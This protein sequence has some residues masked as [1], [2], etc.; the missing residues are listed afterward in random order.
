M[1][2]CSSG[3]IIKDL[4]PGVAE[5]KVEY[6]ALEKELLDVTKESGLQPAPEFLVKCIQLYEMTVVRHGM[7][8][9]GPTGGGKSR[10][11]RTLQ[12]AMSRVK[13]D[14]AFDKRARDDPAATP[15]RSR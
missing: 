2:S 3:S 10:I 9:V 5:P 15:R 1:T 12:A 13:D 8:L 7:M 6:A 11:L 4:F 14:P